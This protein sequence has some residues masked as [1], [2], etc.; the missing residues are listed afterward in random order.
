MTRYFA[1][2]RSWFSPCYAQTPSPQPALQPAAPTLTPIAPGESSIMFAY[3][4][5]CSWRRFILPYPKEPM[6]KTIY[7][8][9]ALP[10]SKTV[11]YNANTRLFE[12]SRGIFYNLYCY[13]RGA[14]PTPFLCLSN[15]AVLPRPPVWRGEKSF[16]LVSC[17]SYLI[18]PHLN[19][20]SWTAC[21]TFFFIV[22]GYPVRIIEHI[23]PSTP[24]QRLVS[25]PFFSP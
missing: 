15:K 4:C 11:H 1:R 8:G 20:V 10:C 14:M 25:S 17:R 21:L 18:L 3:S 7:H 6:D 24:W 19:G 9:A 12:P 23:L 5:N 16:F 22:V 2:P 13:I